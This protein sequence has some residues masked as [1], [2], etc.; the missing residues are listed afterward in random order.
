MTVGF[1]VQ[2]RSMRVRVCHAHLV[3]VVQGLVEVG[4]HASRGLV[5][6]LDGAL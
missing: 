6:D 1:F 5:S 4:Q 3:E 2:L